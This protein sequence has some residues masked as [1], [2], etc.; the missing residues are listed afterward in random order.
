[1]AQLVERWLL[2]PEVHSLN[3]VIGKLYIKK[4]SNTYQSSYSYSG[5]SLKDSLMA[6]SRWLSMSIGD[7]I[8]ATW[9]GLK[10]R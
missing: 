8:T 1:M 4:G 3:P 9:V 10:S 5:Y 7:A 2:P 6:T